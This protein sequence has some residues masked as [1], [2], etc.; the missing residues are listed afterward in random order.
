MNPFEFVMVLVSII[1][2]LGVAE[3]L[4]GIARIL[5]GELKLYWIHAIWVFTLLVMQLQYCWSLF[6][7]EAKSEWVFLDLVRLLTPPITLF[8]ASS[9]LFPS[10]TERID[11]EEYYFAKRK[12]IFGLV[13]GVMFYYGIWSFS[14]S[15]LSAFQFAV[16][17]MTMML[18]ATERPSVHAVLTVVCVVANIL[19]VA[20]FSYTLGNSAYG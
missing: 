4:A 12:P 7:L 16:F 15:L 17:A 19:F 3:L 2:A 11:L 6:D 5:R 20:S 1:I 13:S 8:L 9:L 14:V 10:R 18:F